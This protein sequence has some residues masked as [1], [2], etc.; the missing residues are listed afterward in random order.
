MSQVEVGAFLPTFVYDEGR[1]GQ[2]VAAFAARAEEIGLASLWATDH[3]LHGS[4]FY[5]VPWLEP[6]VALTYA[7]AVTEKVDLGTSVLVMPTRPP[8][9]LA[10][11]VSTLQ[12]LSGDRFILGAGT[13]WD[14]REFT[15]AGTEKRYR[16]VETDEGIEIVAGLLTGDS[17]DYVGRRTRLDGVSIAPA[18]KTPLRLWVGGGRQVA[19]SKSPERPEMPKRVLERIGRADG[20]IARPTSTPDQ[21]ALDLSDIAA[22]F[23]DIGRDIANLTLAH[24]NF[25]HLVDT[26]DPDEARA[27]Q[28]LAFTKMMGDGRPFE[29][30]DQVY[31][32][33]TV[34]EIIEK[35]RLR[36]S[37][38][39]RYFIFHTLEPS[40]HQL[41]MWAE[42]L[43]PHIRGVR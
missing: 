19:H 20:W 3:L 42:T 2:E 32:T 4:L 9:L 11:Q 12:A 38:G 7:A 23:E 21:I 29:Y 1:T 5:A 37:A 8:V 18:M 22:H 15:V 24:E 43:L 14:E 13:G 33:G 28:K 35:I 41:D 27:E 39:I 10:K 31:L 6:L 25:I 26:D 30:F 17:L 36:A 40:L 34:E 16:G